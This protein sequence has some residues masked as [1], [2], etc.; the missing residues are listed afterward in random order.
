[1]ITLKDVEKMK[2]EF[3][4]IHYDRLLNL[5]NGGDTIYFVDKLLRAL[6]DTVSEYEKIEAN[7]NFQLRDKER[8]IRAN[9]KY[10]QD[11]SKK[12]VEL[13]EL[14]SKANSLEEENAKLKKELDQLKKEIIELNGL[15]EMLDFKMAALRLQLNTTYGL[16]V[17]NMSTD[18][19]ESFAEK[20][21]ESIDN[22]SNGCIEASK[23]FEDAMSKLAKLT[24]ERIRE[25]KFETVEDMFIPT[26]ELNFNESAIDL[27]VDENELKE[28]K[29]S[30]PTRE[31]ILNAA[32][33]I[34][35]GD[36]D[37]K[38]GKPED[39]FQT[40]ADLWNTYLGESLRWNIEPEEVAVMM[41]LMKV[42][43]LSKSLTEDSFIDI[44]G[45]A[46]CGGE[47]FG[48][49]VKEADKVMKLLCGDI[50]DEEDD[51]DED[52]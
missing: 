48:A 46:A 13:N 40:I 2:E 52:E 50:P 17:A 47:I 7:Y 31:S 20:F 21:K 29:K 36:R 14:K 41:I 33:S 4:N 43:R 39:N 32:M 37:E 51:E 27:N 9:L 26:K 30:Y 12:T 1:M 45:Y 3:D 42:S 28:D 11:N 22:L 35:N 19:A 44:A 25:G 10:Y 5:N 38:Y 49:N 24:N 34:V 6:D 8:L 18:L 15:K 16:G 23:E